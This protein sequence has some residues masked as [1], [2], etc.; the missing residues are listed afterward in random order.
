[1]AVVREIE[2][3]P[4]SGPEDEA[5]TDD[6]ATDAL[7]RSACRI[8][9]AYGAALQ[10]ER[11][12]GPVAS[13][14]F[15]SHPSQC[16]DGAV[17]LQVDTGRPQGWESGVVVVPTG[18]A[19][20]SAEARGLLVLELIHRAMTE[21]APHR[22]WSTGVLDRIRH[23]VVAAGLGFVWS[24]PWKASPDRRR[25]V[26]AVFRIVDDGFGR[27]ALEVRAR[28]TQELLARSEEW[29]TYGSLHAFR[30]GL[31]TLRWRGST[32]EWAPYVDDD[33]H[34]EQPLDLDPGSWGIAPRPPQ[35]AGAAADEVPPIVL[36]PYGVREDDPAPGFEVA[37]GYGLSARP[38][39]PSTI[40]GVLFDVFVEV[41]LHR[42]VHAPEAVDLREWVGTRSVEVWLFYERSEHLDGSGE[43]YGLKLRRLADRVTVGLVRAP[44]SDDEPELRA[45]ALAI[46]DAIIGAL[47]ERT[48]RR[49]RGK[50][51]S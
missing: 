10:A 16:E 17:T 1:M 36:V 15:F 12:E 41:E 38:T 51:F 37:T 25:E 48:T 46:V 6:P 35:D 23:K 3:W 18:V 40:D 5:W 26:R 20:L 2:F 4:A 7:V 29:L 44:L 28:G 49:P 43:T 21:I 24:S 30:W 39:E 27:G 33:G 11:L 13:L 47:R 19:D 22:G 50:R 34:R 42:R 9:E 32:L 31:K 14:R 45:E 8:S